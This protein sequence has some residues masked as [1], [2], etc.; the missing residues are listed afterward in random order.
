M[1]LI[2]HL[3]SA[4]ERNKRWLVSEIK[5]NAQIVS[6]ANNI[7]NVCHYLIQCSAAAGV[8]ENKNVSGTRKLQCGYKK[9][10]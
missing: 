1:R 4:A 9:K 2:T 5:A 8:L 6:E 7:C 3:L 10:L